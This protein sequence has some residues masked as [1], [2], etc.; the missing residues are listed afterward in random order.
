MDIISDDLEMINKLFNIGIKSYGYK[1]IINIINSFYDDYEL[2][3][4]S[5]GSGIGAIEYF[6]KKENNNIEWICVDINENPIDFPPSAKNNINKPL[7]K[8][9]Y[10]SIDEL[11]EK[12]NSIVNNC[13]IFLNW[14][15]PNESE[16]DFDAIVKLKPLAILS[17]YENNDG[18][19]GCAGGEKFYNWTINNND[20]FLKKMC[21]LYPDKYHINHDDLMDIKI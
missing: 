19:Y 8:I 16:Y 1:N 6:A 21:C 12:N 20:Y 9:D 10:S 17:I 3:I 18:D 11:I 15:L 4:V 7:M 14:C 5:I 13:I 2:P